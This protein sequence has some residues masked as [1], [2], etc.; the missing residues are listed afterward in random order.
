M[1]RMETLDPEIVRRLS[2][3]DETRLRRVAIAVSEFALER[4]NL[5]SPLAREALD[6]LR[7]TGAVSPKVREDLRTLTD[8]LD[9]QYFKLHEAADD[10]DRAAV[11]R[12]VG[13]EGAPWI[14]MFYKARAAN[15]AFF[16]CERDPLVAALESAYEA[17]AT[18]SD[19][20]ASVGIATLKPSLRKV[21]L[22][23][24]EGR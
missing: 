19:E 3:A 16:A 23:A 9:D 21:M 2:R 4:A 17:N 10:T 8:S 11:A 18:L 7:K 12:G 5:Q 1:A 15:A 13:R 22:K 24:L 14:L 6:S 20:K